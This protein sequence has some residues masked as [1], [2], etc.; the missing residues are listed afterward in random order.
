MK[1]RYVDIDKRIAAPDINL[2]FP[3]WEAA[4]ERVCIFS[5]H[6][7]DAIIGAGYAICAAIA[8]GAAVYVAIFC[9]GNAGYSVPE[10]KGAIEKIREAE[11]IKAYQK[12][13]VR[14]EN[15]IRFNYADFSVLQN[16]G[17]MLDNGDEGSFKHTMTT[18]R[19]HRI[20]RLLVPNHYREHIDHTAV[21]CIG[22]YDSPQAGDPILVDW[23]A[24][25]L[26]RSVIEYPVWAD[27]SPQD[28]LLSGRKAGLRGN[29]L[30]VVPEDTERMICAGIAEYA[31]QGEIIKGMIHSRKERC[32]S[33]GEYMEVYLAYDP[34]PKLDYRP[35]QEFIDE[36]GG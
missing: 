10:Q 19:K 16:I 1:I 8:N 18:L 33:S 22:S 23:G 5:P 24:P 14:E 11:S 26:I 15:I 2:L 29:R 9:R 3:D 17:W 28:M 7:D 13:G 35:Y 34:R 36:I 27:L 31:S 20:T 21:S 32:L 25:Q 12:I 4:K 30:V 6:D